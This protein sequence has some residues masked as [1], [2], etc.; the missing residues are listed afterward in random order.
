MRKRRCLGVVRESQAQKIS[1]ST[2][3][4]NGTTRGMIPTGNCAQRTQGICAV[5][6]RKREIRATAKVSHS[7]MRLG[8][9]NSSDREACPEG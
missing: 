8:S 9:S 4:S 6:P 1:N 7:S 3:L 2:F 5:L